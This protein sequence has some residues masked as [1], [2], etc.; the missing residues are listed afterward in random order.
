MSPIHQI[1]CTHC[2]YGTSVLEQREGELADRVLGYSARASSLDRGELRN[3]YRQVE[4]FLY[5]YLPTDTP[6][7]EKLRLDAS[8]AP[9]RM[10][11]S[12]A[13][14][15][16]QVL[17]QIS[18]RQQDTAG[19]P[20]SYFAHVLFSTR[21][22]PWSPLDCL[23]L[24]GAPWAD[25]DSENLPLKL[26]ELQTLDGLLD[27]ARPAIDEAL[28]L[29]F[30]KT[31]LG[32]A[33]DDPRRVIPE[34]WRYVEPADR[35]ELLAET[36]QGY[37]NLGSQRRE[38]LL[39]VVEPSV[40]A[41]AFYGVAR[42]LPPGQVRDG[43]SFSTFEPN[44]DRLP[45]SLAATTFHSPE[46]T[47]LRP[48]A[49]RRRGYVFNTF[50]NRH[51]DHGRPEGHYGRLMVDTLLTAGFEGV[52]QLFGGFQTSGAKTA[53]DLE[54]LAD[55]HQLV[56]QVLD[57]EA[58]LGETRWRQSD[59][60]TR[61]LSQAVHLQ[62]AND[63]AGWPQLRALIGSPNQLLVM[64][65]IAS[66]PA[67]ADIQ[68]P[69]QFLLRK[70]PA[71]KF[72]ELLA[73]ARLAR[74]AKVEALAYYLSSV[75]RF[76]EHCE[77]LWTEGSRLSSIMA[78]RA[79]P[80]LPSV[81]SRLPAQV[82]GP[83]YRTL[84]PEQAELFLL[85]VIRGGRPEP[86]LQAALRAV[87]GDLLKEWDDVSFVAW[88]SEHRD[89]LRSFFP[90][91]DDILRPRL[92]RLLFEIP[93]HPHQLGARLDALEGW[94]DYFSDP[95]LAERRL[96]QWQKIRSILLAIGEAEHHKPANRLEAVFRR[97][98]PPDY[99]ALAEALQSAMPVSVYQDDMKGTR[100]L[101]CLQGLGRSLVGN[102]DFLPAVVR[103]RMVRFFEYGDWS[104]FSSSR[105][106]AKKS[107]KKGNKKYAGRKRKA[108][109]GQWIADSPK[110]FA[111]GAAAAVTLLAGG[112][113]IWLQR[114]KPANSAPSS[115]AAIAGQNPVAKK[116]SAQGESKI[117]DSQIAGAAV[118]D[119]AASEAKPSIESTP[120]APKIDGENDDLA[121]PSAANAEAEG[122]KPEMDSPD[123]KPNPAAGN[124][125]PENNHA[126][127]PTP[128]AEQ[129]PVPG[130]GPRRITKFIELPRASRPQSTASM[131][132]ELFAWSAA[133]KHLKLALHGLESANA[134]LKKNSANQREYP[135]LTM[136]AREP[137]KWTVAVVTLTSD[138]SGPTKDLAI[139]ASLPS[140]LEFRWADT[141]LS[142]QMTAARGWL[143]TCI[144]EQERD[145]VREFLALASPA[146]LDEIHFVNGIAS[147]SPKEGAE[148]PEKFLSEIELRLTSCTVKIDENRLTL[149][150]GIRPSNEIVADAFTSE[151][152]VGSVHVA[153]NRN[154]KQQGT[155]RLTLE[156]DPPAVLLEQRRNL[157]SQ[158][159]DLGAIRQHLAA[160]NKK[161]ATAGQKRT[162]VKT[163]A[164]L[165]NMTPSADEVA[166][167]DAG[168]KE[169]N[170]DMKL[171][172]SDEEIVKAGKTRERELT[173][174]VKSMSEA[175]SAAEQRFK[176]NA[177][178]LR[179]RADSISAVL[180]RNVDE[181]IDVVCVVVGDPEPI[182][183]EPAGKQ[184]ASDKPQ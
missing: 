82:I 101:A 173:V 120:A 102:G 150:E 142:P 113:F 65:L 86:E 118:P 153:L 178:G 161:G 180:T 169:S 137:D 109:L 11:Y 183:D 57:P 107:N 54:L 41:L 99:R 70:L 74:S 95:S 18:Y 33:F 123:E 172:T 146:K 78:G 83:I 12:P 184:P 4:R 73:S 132:V 56:G 164:E 13:I 35:A 162:A 117:G 30:L 31:P 14:G 17:G 2:T 80:L 141:N 105:S 166:P 3:Y 16:I 152:G 75:G 119:K 26:P 66:A 89:E 53:E 100:K 131:P 88:L 121:Q 143:R 136:S 71:D 28:L 157:N 145:G 27:G 72:G 20:G 15:E 156:I 32:E 5:Y 175:L 52:D 96:V 46:T 61:Y 9:R 106:I 160:Y 108:T 112:I 50:L 177:Q 126:V 91:P 38:N 84:S 174:K 69:L 179:A 147:F 167:E 125:G 64:E 124:A 133:P 23:Q 168:G 155:W 93:D 158:Q 154:E 135:Q 90:P 45:V 127:P 63:A 171:Q 122:R 165:L 10:F 40:A 114:D 111:F 34:R 181:G 1:Y 92:A 67:A 144:L 58:P 81:L 163:L 59:V 62:L 104:E 44:A 19:R 21:D 39:L 85:A 94:V 55:V 6:A 77:S 49:Y 79:E 130:A 36:L 129:R 134:S 182:Q 103:S 51:S 87:V 29:T 97:P 47:D 42:L 8:A 176:L 43:I 22:A 170:S 148:L 149:V 159:G 7:E 37:L 60:A 98:K 151:T 76:P 139:F 140:G 115:S 128:E 116:P 24:W 68:G 25:E 138:Q 48:E 110:L